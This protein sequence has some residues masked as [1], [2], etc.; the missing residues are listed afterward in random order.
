MNE[1]LEILQERGFIQQ[2]TDV[3]GLSDMLNKGPISFYVGLDP[4]A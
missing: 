3:E 2:C 1:A 4:T